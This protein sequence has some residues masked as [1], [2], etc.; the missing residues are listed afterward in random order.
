MDHHGPSTGHPVPAGVPAR[1]PEPT[2]H[3]RRW[4]AAP[5]TELA[6]RDGRLVVVKGRPPEA[7]WATLAEGRWLA[8][9]RHAGVVPL[10]LV[11]PDR[12]L[13]ETEFRGPATL[14]TARLPPDRAARVL[15]GVAAVLVGLHRRGLVHGQLWPEHVVLAGAD[16]A[17]PVLCSPAAGGLG[18]GPGTDL[19]DLARL[20]RFTVDARRLDPGRRLQRAWG[21]VVTRLESDPRCTPAQAEAWFTELARVRPARARFVPWSA[22]SRRL[23]RMRPR[24]RDGR[25][26]G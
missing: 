3:E 21:E 6:L 23:R 18:L 26:T 12:G 25:W 4:P 7:R 20:A 2:D 9:A 13:V 15:S 24:Q 16:R 10:R 19:A 22:G 1:E 14:R 11:A 5:L 17:T 8:E